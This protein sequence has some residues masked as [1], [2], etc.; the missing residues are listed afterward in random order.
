MEGANAPDVPVD[1]KQ[2]AGTG[3]L[4]SAPAPTTAVLL[5]WKER[6][7]EMGVDIHTITK[8]EEAMKHYLEREVVKVGAVE[9]A[10]ALVQNRWDQG[11][12]D[13]VSLC[14]IHTISTG[15]YGYE[16]MFTQT[17]TSQLET[18]NC[19]S[20]FIVS[21]N[22]RP[23]MAWPNTDLIMTTGAI[24]MFGFDIG[25]S[26]VPMLKVQEMADWGTALP[27]SPT[28]VTVWNMVLTGSV[29]AQLTRSLRGWGFGNSTAN[30]NAVGI[31]MRTAALGRLS[32]VNPMI[33]LLMYEK[34]MRF[35]TGAT[36]FVDLAYAPSG[37]TVDAL[38]F[39]DSSLATFQP[40]AASGSYFPMSRAIL[41]PAYP[42]AATYSQVA[43]PMRLISLNEFISTWTGI[44]IGTPPAPFAKDNWGNGVAIIPLSDVEMSMLQNQESGVWMWVLSQLEYP[45]GWFTQSVTTILRTAEGSAGEGSERVTPLQAVTMSSTNFVHIPGPNQGILFVDCTNQGRRYD[46]YVA[47]V[48]HTGVAIPILTAVGANN[49]NP[50]V[51]YLVG[52][53]SWAIGVAPANGSILN[54]L[55][56]L[57]MLGFALTGSMGQTPN[58]RARVILPASRIST[59]IASWRAYCTD[60]DVYAIIHAM[61]EL[62]QVANQ[63]STTI[64]SSAIWPTANTY[65]AAGL[66][67]EVRPRCGW[68][69]HP[70][71]TNTVGPPIGTWLNTVDY[72]VPWSILEKAGNPY[73]QCSGASEMV[74]AA[75]TTMS[76][77]PTGYMYVNPVDNTLA[78][79]RLQLNSLIYW[80]GAAFQIP[81][82]DPLT[83]LGLRA[84]WYAAVAQTER[85]PFSESLPFSALAL[86]AA[87]IGTVIADEILGDFLRFTDVRESVNAL[88]NV[89]NTVAALGVSATE[90]RLLALH[91]TQMVFQ[92]MLKSGVGFARYVEGGRVF[93][94]R[95]GW[96]LA[97]NRPSDWVVNKAWLEFLGQ[98]PSTDINGVNVGTFTGLAGPSQGSYWG[99]LSAIPWIREPYFLHPQMV[100][101]LQKEVELEYAS[102]KDMDIS[103]VNIETVTS[104]G[105]RFAQSNMGVNIKMDSTNW[106]K[107]KRFWKAAGRIVMPLTSTVNYNNMAVG[108]GSSD[109]CRFGLHYVDARHTT[110]QAWASTVTQGITN[111]GAVGINYAIDNFPGVLKVYVG[112]TGTPGTVGTIAA[113]RPIWE[114]ALRRG[115]FRDTTIESINQKS[116]RY[117]L[118]VLPCPRHGSA[119]NMWSLTIDAATWA[120]WQNMTPRDR[121][122]PIWVLSG[123]IDSMGNV[124]LGR[125]A[126]PVM[127]FLDY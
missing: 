39:K 60:T 109:A 67:T 9:M 68:A 108:I 15:I 28:A 7:L 105:N 21:I 122:Y 97:V 103:Y 31:L 117:G 101:G 42:I 110:F 76:G 106:K 100:A 111:Y 62:G 89:G 80:T 114:V 84:G 107:F 118:G 20:S 124:M 57:D 27:L 3:Q 32:V 91:I 38:F 52:D 22:M 75:C 79:A 77:A 102:V 115:P 46:G 34:T 44:S 81:T 48:S 65:Q 87:S 5:K 104:G 26:S 74:Y 63:A 19:I 64:K 1:V 56:G 66:M 6:L 95:V 10:K 58:T 99:L 23:A 96:L 73:T 55:G 98:Q 41:R 11:V 59:A 14:N 49:V 86:R 18:T 78:A 82:F 2:Q 29:D 13:S 35:V 85:W 40:G 43:F 116:I 72:S 69:L 83:F 92:T 121:T 53:D 113:F 17:Q 8:A 4:A 119:A 90:I 120:G 30:L 61:M 25:I 33:K 123:S 50:I 127:S 54:E 12:A 37:G 71:Q 112:M 94:D 16:G 126:E 24:P 88:V 47:N 93:F 36:G 51:S 70:L 125:L 45:F